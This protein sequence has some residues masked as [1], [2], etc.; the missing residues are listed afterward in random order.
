MRRRSPV[1]SAGSRLRRWVAAVEEGTPVHRD[2]TVDALRAVAILGVVVGHWLVS[3]V[4]SD[5]HQTSALH[6]ESPLAYAPQLAPVS[7]LLQT[8]GPFFF[9]AGYAAA[10]GGARRRV[11]GRWG[12][13]LWRLARPVMLLLAVWVPA[14]VLAAGVPDVTRHVILSL[15]THPLWFLLAY[16]VLIVL[17]AWLRPLVDR[18]GPWAV[19]PAVVLVALTDAARPVGL[20]SWWVL[21]MVPVGWSV[22][23]L[24]GMSLARDRLSGRRVGAVLLTLGTAGGTGLV[25]IADYP[26]SAVGVP[27]D[28]WSNLDPPSLFALALA[29]AQIGAFLLVRPRLA[30]V[31]RRPGW[32]APV[33]EL[34]RIAMTVFCWH[35]SALLL[36][37]FAAVPVGRVAGLLDVP[38]GDWPWHRLLWL[39]VFA[40][41]LA[42]LIRVFHRC[43]PS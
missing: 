31:L 34:N 38:D 30:A 22:P 13:R 35:Q 4:V 37:T 36:V 26:A 2:R 33:A 3:A 6:G 43:G 25:L 16:L 5:P 17:T 14:V 10:A 12:T 15:I 39:P 24:L 20:P 1:R 9:A 8:L 27:G 19:A 21:L 18:A 29:G 23:F 40:V 28:R 42:G 7:W 32:W 11:P 41:V